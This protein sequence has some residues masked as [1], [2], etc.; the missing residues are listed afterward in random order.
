VIDRQDERRTT[1]C[2]SLLEWRWLNDEPEG[3]TALSER[4]GLSREGVRQ[5]E[6]RFSALVRA[7]L[8]RR[9]R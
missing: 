1:I 9:L 4:L 7:E 3:Y 8:K 6:L 5:N 2:Y